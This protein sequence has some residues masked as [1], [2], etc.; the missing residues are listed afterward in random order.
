M[1]ATGLG[2]FAMT[3]QIDLQVANDGSTPINVPEIPPLA[4]RFSPAVALR[5]VTVER[6][7][8]LPLSRI[9][10]AT[11]IGAEVV[12]ELAKLLSDLPGNVF[13]PDRAGLDIKFEDPHG[14]HVKSGTL[15]LSGPGGTRAIPLDPST[16]RFRLGGLK[17]GVYSLKGASA[18]AGRGTINIDLRRNDITR[19]TL[20]L[21]GIPPE[22]TGSI[23]FAIRGS[24]AREVFIRATDRT[25]GRIVHEGSSR[26]EEGFVQLNDIPIGALHWDI[27][28]GSSRSCYD[29]DLTDASSLHGHVDIHLA[30]PFH[31]TPDPPFSLLPSQFR[32]VIGTLPTL[33]IESLEGLAAMEPEALMHRA[34]QLHEAK[35]NIEPIHPRL[36]AE[37]I[38]AARSRLG[39]AQISGHESDEFRL[40][41]EFS[42]K[43][44]PASAGEAQ[45]EVELGS[46][47]EAELRLD[48]PQGPKTHRIVGSGQISFQVRPEDVAANDAY[49]LSLTS[50]SGMDLSGSVAAQFAIRPGSAVFALPSTKDHIETIYRALAQQNPGLGTT[51]PD[52]VMAPQNIQ[53]W[54]D[55]ART[56]MAAAG[57]CSMNDLGRFRL[58]PMPIL[59]P[60]IYVAPTAR[61][62]I[63]GVVAVPHYAFAGMLSDTVLQYVPNDVKHD[64]AIIMAG[65]WDIHGQAIVIGS[66]VQE[67]AVIARSIKHDAASQITWEVPA[68]G[69]AQAYWPN[70]APAGRNGTSGRAAERGGDGDRNPHPSLNGGADALKAA[71]IVTLYILE[72]SN[73]LPLINLHGQRGGQGGL[74]QDGGRGGDGAKGLDADGTVFGGCCRD[75]G[76]GGSGGHGGAAGWGGKGGRGAVAAEG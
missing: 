21:D 8:Q 63:G 54:L 2:E 64:T 30:P 50:I 68:L 66:D 28:D 9:I 47:Q 44:A 40:V 33:G 1:A 62:S 23:R 42:R 46:G 71:P 22:G 67:L 13:A 11:E 5:E 4:S 25:S 75:P 74:G 51:Q 70:P 3:D 65:E 27:D 43:Y 7:G 18:T 34:Q 72:S 48:G 69:P 26:I 49:T 32:G 52:A 24:E 29:S 36:F 31:V 14:G 20:S 56:F 38:V 60:G 61:P 35:A 39:L 17:P 57:V 45:I 6:P 53:M 59:R 41:R 16:R 15:V 76:F 58:T 37:A 10:P 12:Q 73:G 19:A 55:R